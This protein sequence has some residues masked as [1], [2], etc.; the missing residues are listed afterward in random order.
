[1]LVFSTLLSLSTKIKAK[2]IL[3]GSAA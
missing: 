3:L 2:D 1:V